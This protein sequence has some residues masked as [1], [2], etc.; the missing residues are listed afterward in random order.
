VRLFEIGRNYLLDADGALREVP[1]IAGLAAGPALPEQWGVARAAVD[2]FD[3]KADIE[4]LLRSTGASGDFRFVAAE[5]PALHPGQ[6][7]RIL[8]GAVSVGWIGR[9]HPDVETKLDLTYSAIVFELEMDTALAARVPQYQD[10]S[11]FPSVRRDL[12]LVVGE[13]VPVQALLDRVRDTA[14]ALLREATVFDVYRGTGIETGR[15]SVAIGL[16]L[17]DV[18]RTL[19]DEETDA[20]VARVVADLERECHATIRH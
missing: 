1:V 16:N 13:S 10:V 20:V 3:V 9:L 11:R 6:A 19:T 18:S 2:F 8:R 4:A 12:A 5:H 7:A 15:K 17:Q 14:G